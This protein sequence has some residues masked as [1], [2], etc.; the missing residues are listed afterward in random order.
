MNK[1]VDKN[2]FEIDVMRIAKRGET[3]D[4]GFDLIVTI[5]IF[6][7]APKVVNRHGNDRKTSSNLVAVDGDNGVKVPLR[8]RR[9]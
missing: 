3:G 4:E 2:S 8:R 5:R 6:I 1:A 9:L 7:P